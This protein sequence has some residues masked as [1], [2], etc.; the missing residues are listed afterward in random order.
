MLPL[1]PTTI[2]ARPIATC[3]RCALRGLSL[4]AVIGALAGAIWSTLSAQE[5][6]GAISSDKATS[7]PIRYLVLFDGRVV[8]GGVEE[9]PGGYLV[10]QPGGAIV[11]PFEMIRV[12]AVSLTEAYEKQRDNFAYPT[13]NDHLG[14]AQWCY[15]NKLYAQAN[16]ELEAVLRLEPQRSDARELLKRVDAATRREVARR[17]AGQGSDSG[18]GDR[19]T[20]RI[21]TETHAEFIRR[22]QPLLVNK[23]GNATCHGTAS[24]NGFR[25]ANVRT[26]L[27]HQRLQ[28]DQ[29][30]TA[31]LAQI[32]ADYPQQ[33]KLLLKPQDREML[34]HRGVFF[35]ATGD[36]QVQMLRAWIASAAADLVDSGE[37]A[38]TS[39]APPNDMEAG[40]TRQAAASPPTGPTTPVVESP[41]TAFSRPKPKI[42]EIPRPDSP[43]S[44]DLLKNVLDE[45]RPDPFDP[46]EFNRQVHGLPPRGGPAAPPAAP[47]R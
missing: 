12:A 11:L 25:L 43:R 46:E 13:A 7:T 1:L 33:S 24:S 19:T 34:V 17:T 15:T 36:D 16:A 29:N 4:L 3:S 8:E 39:A 32:S 35:G 10:S 38:E 37:I 5:S 40:L 23:C 30:L 45:E 41:E 20:G 28:S 27:R 18:S 14:L 21:R 2:C 47:P 9:R 26:G 6:G 22:I 44:S 31:V 42:I